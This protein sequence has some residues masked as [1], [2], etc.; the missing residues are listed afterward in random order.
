[1]DLIS[2]FAYPL[3]ATVIAELL[4]VP[5]EDRD[6]YHQWADVIVGLEENSD[7]GY[8][9][10]VSKT[11]DE[12][13]IYFSKLIEERKKNKNSST[14]DEDDLISRIIRAKVDGHSLSEREILTFSHLL[15]NA[16]HITTVN[17]IGNSIFSLLENPQE[18]KRLQENRNSL[19][20][21]AI[22]ETLR[23]RSPV[24]L[25]IRIAN[26]DV[27]LS[28]E[29]GKG[30]RGEGK[31][32]EKQE[33]KKGQ[34]IILFL[35]SANHDESVFTDPERFDITR[36]NLRHMAF[37]TGIHFCLGAPLARLEGQ[38]AL[39]IL[40]ERF[41]NLQFDFDYRDTQDL[42]TKISPLKSSLFL[43]LSHLPIRFQTKN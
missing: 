10:K 37:G 12:M 17:L 32:I 24:Q 3:P 25:V 14:N 30:K 40:L 16:G 23:Y 15:L 33:I 41:D 1:M 34:K 8:I 22:E 11:I 4:G 5:S 35:G 20:K 29:E 43:G 13:D 26:D 31:E 27:T 2:D 36:K 19:I 39:R 7:I 28:E 21:P 9:K 38:I 18:F 42:Y 6:T